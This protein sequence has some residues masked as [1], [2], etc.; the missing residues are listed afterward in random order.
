M[1]G[2]NIETVNDDGGLSFFERYLTLWVVLCIVIGIALGKVA[3]G[4]AT[5]LDRLAITVNGAP[6]VSH[7]SLSLLYDVSHHGED[8][9]RGGG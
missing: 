4:V 1:N 3:P 5:Y 8:R 9:F 6:V 7:R 2:A